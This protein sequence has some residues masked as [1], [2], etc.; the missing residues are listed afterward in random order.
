MLDVMKEVEYF[1]SW[2]QWNACRHGN[3]GSKGP[4]PRQN[5]VLA[6]AHQ[7]QLE[8]RQIIMNLPHLSSLLL[9]CAH[10]GAGA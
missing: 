3:S 6:R 1:P 7:Q 8:C 4:N 9:P 2:K 10:S 5:R